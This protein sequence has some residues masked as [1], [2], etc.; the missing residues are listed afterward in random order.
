MAACLL[1]NTKQ[2]SPE[3]RKRKRKRK[4]KKERKDRRGGRDTDTDT[5]DWRGKREG[6]RGEDQG[7]WRRK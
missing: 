7:G 1:E 6:A 2:L 3:K 4:R 5:D